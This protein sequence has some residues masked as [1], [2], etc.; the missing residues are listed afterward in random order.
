V[1][2]LLNKLILVLVIF[3]NMT[4][5]LFDGTGGLDGDFPFRLLAIIIM[6]IL[7]TKKFGET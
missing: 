1:L 5:K 4:G 7:H 3:L 2:V 6:I